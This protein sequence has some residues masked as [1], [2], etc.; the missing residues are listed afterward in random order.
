MV[1]AGGRRL[2][3]R[4][5]RRRAGVRVRFLASFTL[6]V[7][8]LT[9]SFGLV[10]SYRTSR[11]LYQ[12]VVERGRLLAAQLGKDAFEYAGLED[13]W[14]REISFVL[15]T[16]RAMLED[17]RYVEIVVNNQRLGSAAVEGWKIPRLP[18]NPPWVREVAGTQETVL[19]FFQPLRAAARPTDSYVR[20][21][22]SLQRV[23]AQVRAALRDVV[24]IGVAFIA[25]GFLLALWLYRGIFGPLERL[26]ES[27]R[28]F[29]AGDMTARARVRTGD[30][31]QELAEEFNHMLESIASRDA[32]LQQANLKLAEADQAKSR[33][34]ATMGHEWKTP[35]HTIRGYA[36]LLAEEVD[37]PL[38][39]AQ[40]SDVEALLG[41][42]NHLLDLIDNLLNFIR[43]EY[44][45]E[46]NHLEALDLAALAREAWE[47]VRPAA[48]AGRLE[49]VDELPP[50]LP[51]VGDRTKLKQVLINLLSNA[52]KY[53]RCGRVTVRGGL[54]PEGAWLAVTDTGPGIPEELREKIFQPFFRGIDAGSPA[55]GLGLGLALV[56]RYVE[57]HGGQVGVSSRPGEGSTF[58]VRLPHQRLDAV[59]SKGG[60][61][62]AGAGG[63]GQPVVRPPGGEVPAGTGTRGRAG[64]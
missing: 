34:L 25:G 54:E 40:R 3:R 36:Q 63:R 22:L 51:V 8:L 5:G 17:A 48:L 57:A 52:A 61:G 28:R 46:P 62:R 13:R 16:N 18:E 60:D 6:L 31:I 56:R 30:E 43:T 20:V 21:G 59:R 26:M 27:V 64:P 49:F 7:V 23:Q 11:S 55:E 2:W 39:A 29:Q 41:A 33:F 42:A 35:L 50:R 38:T 10:A 47:H 44:S 9:F 4:P 45:E 53:T 32:A 1:G 12:Q 15:L 14:R 37:G 58:T 24:L 19:E